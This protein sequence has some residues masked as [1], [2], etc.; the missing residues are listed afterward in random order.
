MNAFAARARRLL[1]AA[2]AEQVVDGLDHG[3]SVDAK[4]WGG[5]CLWRAPGWDPRRLGG[6]PGLLDKAVAHSPKDADARAWRGRV[7]RLLG[8]PAGA[9]ADLKAAL[10]L[11]P[12]H[13][14]ARAALA[15]LARAQAD[16]G[17]EEDYERALKAD[18]ALPWTRLWR[19]AGSLSEGRLS[20]AGRDLE[21]LGAAGRRLFIGR[22]LAGLLAGKL[23]DHAAA[24]GQF[25]AAAALDPA[26]PAAVVLR[27]QSRLWSGDEAGAAE[28]FEAAIRI[29]HDCKV[30]YYSFLGTGD[31]PDTPEGLAALDEA[32]RKRP[33]A[34]WVWALRGEL[35]RMPNLARY[36]EATADLR[37]AV[38]LAPRSPWLNAFLGRSL[39]NTGR[40]AEGL[41]ALE[42]GLALDPE[43]GWIHGWRGEALRKARRYKDAEAALTRAVELSPGYMHAWAWRGTVRR[44]LG[45]PKEALGDLDAAVDLNPLY[46]LAY[47]NRALAR[48][49]AG[50]APGAME[51]M[52]RAARMNPK[53]AFFDGPPAGREAEAKA[54]LAR[55]SAAAKKDKSGRALAWRGET[56]LKTG[57]LEGALADL[58]AAARKA[59]RFAW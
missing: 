26:C 40:G 54:V 31:L 56:R 52:E 3:T 7:K 58:A 30:A 34:P 14:Y 51:D 10:R 6:A 19:A 55:L 25:D 27:G 12:K 4:H 23:K 44:Q 38:S 50:D 32:V 13:A 57:D 35:Q 47:H 41:A 2:R 8:D 18:P 1:D 33:K 22:V 28:D 49:E 24:R 17:W 45:R 16:R 48:L 59:P 11:D 42:K 46:D 36:E 20:E 29:D 43:C 53:Y 9:R 37:R 39:G 5:Y 15:E 21:A